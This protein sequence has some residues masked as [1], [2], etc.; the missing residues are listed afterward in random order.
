MMLKNIIAI[1]GDEKG[2]FSVKFYSGYYCFEIIEEII[3]SSFEEVDDCDLH[4]SLKVLS[5]EKGLI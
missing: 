3:W 5:Q 4:I 2:Y 1:D